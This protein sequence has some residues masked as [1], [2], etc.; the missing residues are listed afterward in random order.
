MSNPLRG[1]NIV[2]PDEL[3]DIPVGSIIH[4]GNTLPEYRKPNHPEL[5]DTSVWFVFTAGKAVVIDS[6]Y[7]ASETEDLDWFKRW[8]VTILGTNQEYTKK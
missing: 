2:A 5:E 7:P 1:N 8:E 4:V 6:F 3:M